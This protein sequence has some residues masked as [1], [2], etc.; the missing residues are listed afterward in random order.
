MRKF[1]G[2]LTPLSPFE[3]GNPDEWDGGLRVVVG[4]PFGSA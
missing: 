2:T 3:E 4:R 1:N